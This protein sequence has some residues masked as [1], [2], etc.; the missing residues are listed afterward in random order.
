MNLSA[1]Q[2]QTSSKAA[3]TGTTTSQNLKKSKEG[4]VALQG[5]GGILQDAEKRP[6]QSTRNTEQGGDR[7]HLMSPDPRDGQ[8]KLT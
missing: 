8:Q 6:P 1:N 7:K 5:K 2:I 4:K 3:T